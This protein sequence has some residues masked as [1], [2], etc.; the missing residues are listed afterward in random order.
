MTA[1]SGPFSLAFV[2]GGV[3]RTLGLAAFP[4]VYRAVRGEPVRRRIGGR[5]PLRPSSLGYF[6]VSYFPVSASLA[7]A[8]SIVSP[9]P[10]SRARS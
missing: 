3:V 8:K 4:T 10:A 7:G 1:L 2:G 5:K 6:P 9:I